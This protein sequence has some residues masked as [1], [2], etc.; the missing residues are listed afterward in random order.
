[1]RKR[2]VVM[3][4]I[5][6]ATVLLLTGCG[7]KKE[8][9][10]QEP[11]EVELNVLVNNEQKGA[12]ENSSEDDTE[13][14][15]D[16]PVKFDCLDEIKAASPD[17][18]LIQI[19]DMILQYGVTGEELFEVIAQSECEYTTDYN[20]NQLVPAGEYEMV[21]FKKNGENYFSISFKNFGAETTEIKNCIAEGISALNSSKGN[22]YYAGVYGE[23]VTYNSVKESMG[24]YE[25]EREFTGHDSRQNKRLAVLYIIPDSSDI[26]QRDELYIYFIFDS[27]T[28]ELSSFWICDFEYSDFSLPW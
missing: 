19:D 26:A 11:V 14:I 23:P 21:R 13:I 28:N 15:P 9:A 6:V 7:S 12:E 22:A 1:M 4:V 3:T 5:T 2:K 18:G 25:P 8:E 10:T 24:D 16:I 20:E 17:S 27:D